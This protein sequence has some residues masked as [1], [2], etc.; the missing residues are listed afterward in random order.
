MSIIKIKGYK[1]Y[2][3]EIDTTNESPAGAV[4][5][6]EDAVGMTAGSSEW[7]NTPIFKNIKPCL[8]K[9]GK[10]QYYLNPDDFT[11]KADGSPADITSGDDGDVMIEIPKL[12]FNI[13]TKNDILSVKVSTGINKRKFKYYAHTR[14]KEG[15]RDKLYVS[16]YLGSLKDGKLRSLSG[17]DPQGSVSIT[18]FRT[19]AQAN[20]EGYDQM[21]F[22]PLTLLQCLFLLKYKS[23]D[24]Q[25]ALGQGLVGA[26]AKVNTGGA[27]KKGMYYGGD[28]TEQVKFAGIEDFWGNLY[29]WI[30]GLFS[31]ASRNILTGFKDFNNTG[32]NYDD[33]GQGATG[34][35][36]GWITQVQGTSEKGLL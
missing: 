3:V 23:R 16:A 29:Y 2:G 1:T 27:D 4:S 35:L 26:S 24:S 5:Y 15:D 21:A 30:D 32:A 14:D 20:G 28:G 25:T 34:D 19:Y 18:D 9:E 6:I 11:Q 33:H 13:E 17:K 31:N 10:V 7:D 8:F 22:Y 36:D 12:G